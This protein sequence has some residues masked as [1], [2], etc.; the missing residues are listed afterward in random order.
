LNFLTKADL[1]P[2]ILTI[3]GMAFGFLVS[4]LGF[5]LTRFFTRTEN[6]REDI[7]NI[8]RAIGLLDA[9]RK[10]S[11]EED[12]SIKARLKEAEREIQKLRERV[13]VLEQ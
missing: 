2:E 1:S 11:K 13:V 8:N 6:S 5:F 7:A 10:R 9:A 12:D 4:A 3:V